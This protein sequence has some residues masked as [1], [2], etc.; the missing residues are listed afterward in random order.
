MTKLGK[1]ARTALEILQEGGYWRS[2]LETGYM[3]REQFVT[4]LRNKDGYTVPGF[5]IKTKFEME[6]AGLLTTR[7]VRSSSTWPTEWVLRN[8]N[9]GE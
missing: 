5:G 7:E 2:Q 6:D 4:R 9:T 3:G 8:T 1:K